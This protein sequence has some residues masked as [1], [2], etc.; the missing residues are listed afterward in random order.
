MCYVVIDLEMCE[1]PKANRNGNYRWANE[2]I[3]I[4]AVMLNKEYEIVDEFMTYVSPEYGC[5]SSRINKLT[6]ISNKQV[7]DAPNMKTALKRF[8]EWLPENTFLVAWSENDE[9]QIKHEI[10]GKAIEFDGINKLTDNWMDCQET[11]SE[12]MNS[13]RRYNL[14]EALILSDIDYNSQFHDGLIDA[15]NTALLFKKMNT[16]KEFSFNTYYLKSKEEPEKLTSTLG[17]LF[18]GLDMLKTA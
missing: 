18:A 14:E 2:T 4:G 15:S 9:A 1:V 17:S 13:K 8:A 5:I 7:I 6:G 12:I 3:Q 16:E 11:F 10:K